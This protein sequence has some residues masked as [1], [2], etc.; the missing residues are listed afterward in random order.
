MPLHP[1]ASA[2]LL[3]FHHAS[4]FASRGGVITDLDGTAVYERDGRV[5]VAEPVAEGLKAL[6]E[7][8]R[9]VVINTLRFPLNVIR[10]FGR[11]W[12]AI[13]A[14]P[15][16]LVSLNGSVIGLLEPTDV[17]ETTFDEL[18]AFPLSAEQLE[19]VA[20]RLDTFLSG[21]VDDI[22]VFH[23]PRD[24][25]R[26]ELV[27]T[28]RADRVAALRDKYR[29]ASEVRAGSLDGFRTSLLRD[30]ACMLSVVV[31]V[32]ADRLM[33]YQHT[34]PSGF[35][36]APG[37][38]KLSGAR[39]AAA[40]LG[41]DLAESVGAGDTPMDR[42]LVGCGLAIQVGPM[43]LEYRGRTGTIRLRDPFELGDALFELAKLPH[44]ATAA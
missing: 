18:V 44:Q 16:P 26:G 10:T 30:G 43:S 38:D 14:N 21:G 20:V 32:P 13:T 41:F 40:R 22:V 33:A 34:D 37:V 5:F 7:R 42:F 8:E 24:W 3:D 4:D 31:D 1:D 9:P 2:A 27:W 6:V 23:Y 39:E 12:S 17:G 11:E 35:L 15:V 29:S 25:R 28:P 19:E 36:T